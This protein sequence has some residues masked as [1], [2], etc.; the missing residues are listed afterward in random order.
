MSAGDELKGRALDLAEDWGIC[1]RI[2]HCCVNSACTN[3][4]CSLLGVLEGDV[5]NKKQAQL[6]VQLCLR[7]CREPQVRVKLLED[8]LVPL[9]CLHLALDLVP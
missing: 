3:A 9:T 5:G 6:A 7:Q 2:S 8:L 1:E 4:C